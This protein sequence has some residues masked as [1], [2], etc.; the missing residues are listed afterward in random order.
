MIFEYGIEF[1]GKELFYKIESLTEESKK[2]LQE[3]M[4]EALKERVRIL[5]KEGK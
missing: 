5:L 4:K 2:I 1:E 3:D